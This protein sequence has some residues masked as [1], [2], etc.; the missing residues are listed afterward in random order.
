MGLQKYRADSFE[1]QG[2]G[3]KLWFAN[4]IGGPSLSK[5]VN[6]RLDNLEGDIRRTVYISGDADTWFSIP[7]KTVLHGCTVTGYVTR[8]DNGNAVFRH[9][10]Y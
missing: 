6:C 9:C 4:W 8:D 1:T 3:A 7:A 2:D 5:I 10:Y